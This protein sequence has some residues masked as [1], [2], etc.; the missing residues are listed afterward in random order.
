MT[1]ST[2]KTYADK[3]IVEWAKEY[4]G[5]DDVLYVSYIYEPA[6]QYSEYTWDPEINTV[7]I[8]FG[9]QDGK[10]TRL[11]TDLQLHEV[12]AKVVEF[13]T[14]YIGHTDE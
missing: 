7:Y 8:W 3:L 2:H 11:H 12:L 13:A 5:R 1:D 4:T 9:E 14:A 6:Y 10:Q